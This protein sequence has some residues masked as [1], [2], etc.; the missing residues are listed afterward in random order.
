MGS[1][2]VSVGQCASRCTATFR[3]TLQKA[4]EDRRETSAQWF[5]KGNYVKSHL[6]DDV[7]KML[8]ITQ[9]VEMTKLHFCSWENEPLLHSI[10]LFLMWWLRNFTSKCEQMTLLDSTQ[11][12]V[13]VLP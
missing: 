8:F 10:I 9:S 12:T 13:E 2:M 7:K 3:E 6:P 4:A 5:S 1:L 11:P